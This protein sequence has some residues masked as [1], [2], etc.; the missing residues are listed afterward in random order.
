MPELTQGEM[1]VIRRSLHSVF[2]RMET[3]KLKLDAAMIELA[4][5]VSK[6]EPR[7][8]T[9]ALHYMRSGVDEWMIERSKKQRAS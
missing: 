3:R 9:T 6:F 1:F 4:F 5:A 2:K 7:A 8:Q